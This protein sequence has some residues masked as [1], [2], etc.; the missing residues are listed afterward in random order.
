MRPVVCSPPLTVAAAAALLPSRAACASL[1]PPTY[2]TA[3]ALA[4]T[5]GAPDR[6]NPTIRHRRLG[7]ALRVAAIVAAAGSMPL[8]QNL[9]HVGVRRVRS[10]P[11][12]PAFA[13]VPRAFV[14][15]KVVISSTPAPP[16]RCRRR[17]RCC[18]R[19]APTATRSTRICG[20]TT[21]PE[22]S[23]MSQ[24]VA[25][26]RSSPLAVAIL[27]PEAHR[28]P[29]HQARTFVD[30]VTTPPMPPPPPSVDRGCA[31]AVVEPRHGTHARRAEAEV[32]VP[33]C[34][35][36]AASADAAAAATAA[37]GG[38]VAP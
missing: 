34:E 27:D 2:R 22:P 5:L 17:R 11:A 36:A 23:V 12:L 1:F 20:V 18:S 16:H 19:L 13:V 37:A 15:G 8:L 24:E 14:T 28:P 4:P 31:T 3:G 29:P 6:C 26:R 33:W 38:G 35:S 25:N 21:G 10:D 7:L 32:T 30:V 9:E